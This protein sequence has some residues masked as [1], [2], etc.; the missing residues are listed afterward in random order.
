M[1]FRVTGNH[2]AAF[3]L[4]PDNRLWTLINITV[5][6]GLTLY[7]FQSNFLKKVPAPS[8]KSTLVRVGKKGQALRTLVCE[9]PLFFSLIIAGGLSNV[10]DRV[11]LGH[12]R[13]FI[14]FKVW[15]AFN[16]AD[17]FVSLGAAGLIFKSFIT[18]GVK[19]NTS[20]V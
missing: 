3:G 11:F 20:K 19:I 7:V 8:Q 1:F 6:T 17:A 10:I 18:S 2:G 14:D 9:A 13:D 12:V 15:P 16:L 4:F 5:L